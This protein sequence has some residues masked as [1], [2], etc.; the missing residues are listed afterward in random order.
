MRLGMQAVL[1]TVLA[2]LF[3]L[4]VSWQRTAHFAIDPRPYYAAGVVVLIFWVIS[5]FYTFIRK[6][7]S[8]AAMLFAIGYLIPF[9]LCGSTFTYFALSLHGH[10]ID[11]ILAAGDR[12][13]GVNW[14]GIMRWAAYHPFAT[15]VLGVAYYYA[16]YQLPLLMVIAGI[17]NRP[18]VIW[19]SLFAISMASL[20]T[21]FFWAAFP[22]FGAFS[23]YRIPGEISSK[24]AL[25]LDSTYGHALGGM[26]G[27]MPRNISPY[28]VKG[29]VGFP[30][31]HVIESV[32]VTFYL[33]PWRWLFFPALAFNAIA[34]AATP[35]QGGHH[36]IDIIGGLTVSMVAIIAARRLYNVINTI[37]EKPRWLNPRAYN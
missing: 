20:V 6:D 35:I 22:S 9:S 13:I 2:A 11:D 18:D 21:I 26:L 15:G 34:I 24:L 36:I 28:S 3:S 29:L 8:P 19:R 32:L 10:R 31:F 25:V 1:L 4:D 23:V 16:I 5:F 37:S 33:W 17:S 14:I 12:A 27:Q 30:S 7:N